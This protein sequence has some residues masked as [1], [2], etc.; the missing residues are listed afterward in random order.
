MG[1]EGRLGQEWHQREHP[2]LEQ[3]FEKYVVR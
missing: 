3:F 2:V 1:S